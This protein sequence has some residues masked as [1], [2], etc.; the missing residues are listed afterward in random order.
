MSK[1]Q[2]EIRQFQTKYFEVN[3]KTIIT[4]AVINTL[5]DEGF[6]I[7]NANNELGIITAEKGYDINKDYESEKSKNI[8]SLIIVGAV[9]ILTLG[10]I[11]LISKDKKSDNQ[12][13]NTNDKRDYQTT[14]EKNKI[15]QATINISEFSN[16][17]KVRAVF[18]SKILNNRGEIV[19]IEQIEDINFYQKFFE[20]LEKS[21]FLQKELESK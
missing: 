13:D 9:I 4:K 21:I 10:L 15:I 16:G 3:D 14:Y 18:Q 8:W 1:S 11:L 5:L 17:F 20:K 7:N 2:L 12:K 19:T 6:I